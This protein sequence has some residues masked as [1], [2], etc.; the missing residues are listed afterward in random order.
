MTN[1]QLTEI[2]SESSKLV[3]QAQKY[4]VG[5][6]LEYDTA[7][8][9][10]KT[11]MNLKKRIE[12]FFEPT[13]NNFKKT[14]AKAEEGRKAEV[15]K[16]N[17]YLAPV[18]AAIKIVRQKCKEFENEAEKKRLEEQTRLDKEAEE[19]ADVKKEWG[20]ENPKVEAEKAET[21]IA[22]TSGLGIR[23]TWKWRI[24]DA[25]KIPR[26]YLRVDE[27][28]INKEVRENKDKTQIEGIEVYYE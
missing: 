4:E 9:F 12:L 23:R 17:D 27:V 1:N 10:L 25:A 22:K 2:S 24:I 11:C 26:K 19:K 16:M 5:N 8:N 18:E 13:I 20:E 15:N 14:K 21:S 7:G 28:M 3:Q 6:Q